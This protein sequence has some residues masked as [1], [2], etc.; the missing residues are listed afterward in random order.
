MNKFQIQIST[1][2]KI[3]PR[4]SIVK[5]TYDTPMTGRCVEYLFLGSCS[6]ELG[7]NLQDAKFDADISY[8]FKNCL[9][10]N[11]C[12]GVCYYADPKDLED[13][14]SFE[15]LRY[16]MKD[17][18]NGMDR[19]KFEALLDDFKKRYPCKINNRKDLF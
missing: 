17:W 7:D 11:T 8:T 12:S 3:L 15:V 4:G 2:N 10:L 19:F 18:Q 6:V 14:S 9:E 1:K 5:H 16:G 13:E